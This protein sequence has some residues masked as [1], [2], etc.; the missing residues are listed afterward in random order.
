MSFVRTLKG[1]ASVT[2]SRQVLHVTLTI[3]LLTAFTKVFYFVKDL[4]V[5]GY[6]GR[7][8]DLDAF[9]IAYVM[10]TFVLNIL[11]A[12][13]GAA[14]IPAIVKMR[15]EEGAENSNKLLSGITTIYAG[16]LVCV[17]G[18]IIIGAPEY[19]PYLASGFPPE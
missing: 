18:G 13:L 6:F 15:K 1:W 17:A 7:S 12:Q 4:L 10:P 9:L 19:L 3:G 16:V 2:P 5:A 14:L 8:D 11:T